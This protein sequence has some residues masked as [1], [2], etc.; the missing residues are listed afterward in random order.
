MV[1]S[2]IDRQFSIV[3]LKYH[4]EIPPSVAFFPRYGCGFVSREDFVWL[5]RWQPCDWIAATADADAWW[6]LGSLGILG[7]SGTNREHYPLVMST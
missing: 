1:N 5:D 2:S 3:M 6:D 7:I 4:R